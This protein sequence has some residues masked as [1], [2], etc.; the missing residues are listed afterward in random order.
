MIFRFV[1]ALGLIVRFAPAQQACKPVEGDELLGKDLAGALP[2]F[3]RIPPDTFLASMPLPGSQRILHAAE[4]ASLAQRY[5]IRLESPE[6][7]CFEWSMQPLNRDHVVEAMRSALGAPGA[8]I[9]IAEMSL[10]K[11]PPGRIEFPR[12]RLASGGSPA[13][14]RGDVIY[15]G[16]HRFAIWA[17]VHIQVTCERL[18]AAENLRSGQIVAPGTVKSRTGQC[19]P[20][21]KEPISPNQAVGMEVL[22]P[23]SAGV[24]IRPDMLAVPNDVNRGDT[25]Q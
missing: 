11:V 24:E 10:Y 4:L 14:W 3:Q 12:D 6:D 13:L 22:H 18:V 25:V 5:S 19:F 2:E 17:R 16:S 20:G 21:G 23:V 15:G 1:V 9:Q 8:E 7:V